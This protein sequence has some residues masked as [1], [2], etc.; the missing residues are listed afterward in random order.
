MNHRII[1]ESEVWE[2]QNKSRLIPITLALTEES[3]LKHQQGRKMKSANI[4]WKLIEAFV[5]EKENDCKYIFRIG[6]G[7][8]FKEFYV[9]TSEM[10]DE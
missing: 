10:L 9:A 1:F 3:I 4:K 5:E 6:Q 2:F 8:I 7:S